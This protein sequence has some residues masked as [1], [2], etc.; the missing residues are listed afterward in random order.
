MESLGWIL[1]I[2]WVAGLGFLV[3]NKLGTF[4]ESNEAFLKKEQKNTDTSENTDRTAELVY[5]AQMDKKSQY[6]C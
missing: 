3:V 5:K 2:V 6:L 1:V 4:M